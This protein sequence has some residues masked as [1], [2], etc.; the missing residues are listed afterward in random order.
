MCDASTS[1]NAQAP[2]RHVLSEDARQ[3]VWNNY[4]YF[5]SI[6][7]GYRGLRDILFSQCYLRGTACLRSNNT[8]LYEKVKEFTPPGVS[9]N[10]Y[11]D[12]VDFCKTTKVRGTTDASYAFLR[13]PQNYAYTRTTRKPVER[14]FSPQPKSQSTSQPRSRNKTD[15]EDDNE[16]EKQPKGKKSLDVDT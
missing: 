11:S 6:N 12:S 5:K 14:N 3:I 4:K 1:H 16:Q 13:C 8:I 15:E 7:S 10:V 2:Q 9:R